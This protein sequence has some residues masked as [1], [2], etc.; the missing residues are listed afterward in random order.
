M[1]KPN[2]SLEDHLR[3]GTLQGQLEANTYDFI[4]FQQGPSSQKSSGEHLLQYATEINRIVRDAHIK[5]V[6]YMVWPSKVYYQTFDNSIEYYLMANHA[7]KGILAPV[8]LIWKEVEDDGIFSVYGE[9]QF[10]PSLKGSFLSAWVIYH[11]LFPSEKAYPYHRQYK[12]YLTQT[13]FDSLVSISGNYLMGEASTRNIYQQA[14]EAYKNN[15]FLSF[16]QKLLWLDLQLPENPSVLYNLA[17]AYTLTGNNEKAV[18]TL[19]QALWL[20]SELP[21]ESEEDFSSL[22]EMDSY[23]SMVKWHQELIE[24][25]KIGVTAWKLEEMDFHPEGITYDAEQG[26]YYIGSVRKGKIIHIKKGGEFE[27]LDLTGKLQS[28]LGMQVYNGRLWICSTPIPEMMG[29]EESMQAALLCWDIQSETL[30]TSYAAPHPRAILG[31]LVVSNSGTVYISNSDTKHPVIYQ[32]NDKESV[33]EV[34]YDGENDGLISLQG[35][36]LD[37]TD[38]YLFFSDYKYGLFRLE[39]STGSIEKMGYKYPLKGIDGLS[40]YH[41][42]LIAIHNGLSPHRIMKYEL[43]KGLDHIEHADYLEKALPEMDEP[44]LGVVVGDEFYYVANSPWAYYDENKNILTEKISA[45]II[46]KFSLK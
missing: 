45:P 14:A 46:R 5:V 24:P 26:T 25:K 3:S 31:D 42:A 11:S 2:Y 28:A 39:L 1:C 38:S 15:N 29:F 18:E 7:I 41:G 21:F 8:G 17:A 20:N 10:H 40:Y 9:D 35:L 27:E 37:H 13:D 33:L 23:Q 12:K 4:V 32:L 43:N 36:A 6:T 30:L 19:Q 34:I 44:T 22:H 16:F